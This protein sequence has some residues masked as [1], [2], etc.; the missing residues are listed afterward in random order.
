MR[1]PSLFINRRQ[2]MVGGLSAALIAGCS[3]RSSWS[4]SEAD[5]VVIGGGMAGVAAALTLEEQ[6]VKVQIVEADKQL[7]GRC[8]SL[9]TQD[10]AFDC[11]ATTI[12]PNYGSV[13]YHANRADVPFIAPNSKDGFSYHIN[14][15]FVHPNAWQS[16]SANL[17]VGNERSLL[18]EQ[19]EFPTVMQHNKITDIHNWNADE[20]LAFDVPLGQYLKEN[21]VSEEA[22]RLIDLT[23]NTMGLD[24]TSAL[25]QMREFAGIAPPKAGDEVREVYDAAGGP[26]GFYN[27]EGGMLTLIERISANLKS[28][29]ILSDAVSAIN[30]EKD[31]ATVTLASGKSIRAKSVICTVPYSAISSIAI[32]PAPTGPK[33]AA[34]ENSLYTLTTHVFFIPTQ[35]YWEKDGHPA[36]MVSDDIVERVMANHDKDGKVAWL[37]VWINGTAAAKFDKMEE[38]EMVGFVQRRL[39]KLRPSMKGALSPV[40]AYSWGRN[41]YVRGNKHVMR[42]GDVRGMSNWMAT[43]ILD[44]LRFAGEHTRTTQ[45]G[46]EAAAAS[47]MREA[48]AYME[49]FA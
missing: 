7:G 44:R 15:Q 21:G 6:G 12:G 31:A 2:A 26:P 41:P 10:G 1:K 11:G 42:P 35:P 5:V 18:P 39:G 30:V 14:G 47:G 13:L 9:R 43:P 3:P 17:M 28:E 33:K 22:L 32:T 19:L 20:L 46:L 49:M 40:G 4:S 23:S 27:V 36:G 25:F 37:D 48:V 34:L 45:A 8:F 38:K 16:S 24:Q 29:P